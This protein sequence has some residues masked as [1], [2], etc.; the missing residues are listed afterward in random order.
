[1]ENLALK[2]KQTLSKVFGLKEVPD[3]LSQETF[4]KWDSLRH[5]NLVV[6]LE[7]EFGVTFTAGD[8]STLTS[9]KAIL[10]ALEHK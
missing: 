6:A 5:L 2:I 3:D 4:K 1:M 9:Y 8:I 7:E 10:D